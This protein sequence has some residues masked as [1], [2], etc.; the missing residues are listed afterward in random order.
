MGSDQHWTPVLQ[1]E[2]NK[3][4]TAILELDTPF[5]RKDKQSNTAQEEVI[6]P[7]LNIDSADV[8]VMQ[9]VIIFFII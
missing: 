5:V 8:S 2:I 9:P 3:K 4:D 1:E 7:K 6:V